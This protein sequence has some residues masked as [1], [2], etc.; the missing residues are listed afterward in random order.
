[1]NWDSQ[2]KVVLSM[3]VPLFSYIVSSILLLPTLTT[4]FI[5]LTSNESIRAFKR[6]Y[7]H[8]CVKKGGIYCGLINRFYIQK[9]RCVHGQGNLLVETT[10]V[11]SRGR[12]RAY[13]CYFIFFLICCFFIQFYIQIPLF[14]TPALDKSYNVWYNSSRDTKRY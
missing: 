3:F 6:I 10:Y 1:M 14:Y 5:F 8:K 7:F 9:V 2:I 11:N 4:Y 12:I 13:D